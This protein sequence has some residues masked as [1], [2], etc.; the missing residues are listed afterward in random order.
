MWLRSGIL[1]L[2]CACCACKSDPQIEKA[3]KA[4]SEQETRL[5][6]QAQRLVEV[7]QKELA[8]G[9]YAEA[10][11]LASKANMLQPSDPEID[12][13]LKQVTATWFLRARPAANAL[14]PNLRA[15]RLE[16][17]ALSSDPQTDVKPIFQLVDAI[18]QIRGGKVQEGRQILDSLKTLKNDVLNGQRAVVLFELGKLSIGFKDPSGAMG[19]FREALAEESNFWEAR[20]Q[21]AQLLSQNGKHKEAIEQIELVSKVKVDGV[22]RFV[23]GRIYQ[24]AGEFARAIDAYERALKFQ[25]VPAAVNGDLAQAYFTQKKYPEARAYFAKSYASTRKLSDLFNQGVALKGM[26]AFAQGAAVFD[27]VVQLEPTSGRA[28]VELISTLLSAKNSVAANQALKRYMAL[29][30]KEKSLEGVYQEIVALV[31]ASNKA[32]AAPLPSNG[33]K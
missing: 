18:V 31:Q 29:K 6:G 32:V 7:A 2:M 19:F 28:H 27:Q 10:R 13:F 14:S 16:L 5:S 4:F 30:E 23:E 17:S 8:E 9:R 20:L 15:D 12:L 11:L 33:K 3:A 24:K 21:L 25:N 26:K 22:V 1:A